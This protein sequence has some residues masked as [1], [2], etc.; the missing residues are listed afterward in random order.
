MSLTHGH[1][2]HTKTKRSQVETIFVDHTMQY[3]HCTQSKVMHLKDGPKKV[4]TT[5]PT[6]MLIMLHSSAAA[7]WIHDCT[8]KGQG[9]G[10][11]HQKDVA[12]CSI[13]TVIMPHSIIHCPGGARLELWPMAMDQAIAIH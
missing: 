10:A 5:L 3:V 6:I 8:N 1:L 2:G 12:E 4:A 9:V 11:H 13:Q 7:K